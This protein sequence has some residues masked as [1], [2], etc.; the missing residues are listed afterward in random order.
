MNAVR[1]SLG[2]HKHG[3]TSI[4][5]SV[6]VSKQKRR[7]RT[8][9]GAVRGRR[10]GDILVGDVE[11]GARHRPLSRCTRLT[12]RRRRGVRSFEEAYTANARADRVHLDV[13]NATRIK[14]IGMVQV[15][16]GS[17][18]QSRRRRIV[19]RNGRH[20]EVVKRTDNS[21]YRGV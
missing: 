3:T 10:E 16:F 2:L 4:L 9:T 13:P 6:V 1:D 20:Y 17:A 5:I 19:F 18:K 8:V 12:H 21:I 11:H 14:P 15:A 7:H